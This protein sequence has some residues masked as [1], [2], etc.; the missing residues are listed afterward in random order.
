MPAKTLLRRF[1]LSAHTLFVSIFYALRNSLLA[2]IPVRNDLL[3]F[4]TH[5]RKRED[6]YIEGF[7]GAGGCIRHQQYYSGVSLRTLF[8]VKV[9]IK[10]HL[11]PVFSSLLISFFLWT[12]YVYKYCVP[13]LKTNTPL[14]L[15][16]EFCLLLYLMHT[17]TSWISDI[18]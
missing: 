18:Q 1:T 6:I 13:L 4:P 3:L 11:L 7:M 16:F 14:A 9:T 15:G 12:N 5:A 8:C 2:F 17:C 10:S